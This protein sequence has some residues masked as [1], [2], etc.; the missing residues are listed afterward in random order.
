MAGSGSKPAVWTN[1]RRAVVARI[2]SGVGPRAH[3]SLDHQRTHGR[4]PRQ[5]KS[6]SC[7]LISHSGATAAVQSDGEGPLRGSG[8][9]RIELANPRAPTTLRFSEIT[10]G[11]T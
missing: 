11:P 3:D 8:C 1:P 5:E 6:P 2:P 7:A 4:P 9:R 10:A